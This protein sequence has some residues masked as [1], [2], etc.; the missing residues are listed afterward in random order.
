MVA[1]FLVLGRIHAF[2]IDPIGKLVVMDLEI[3]SYRIRAKS[4][5]IWLRSLYTEAI[6]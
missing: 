1:G 5:T 3:K 6:N 2:M 4:P